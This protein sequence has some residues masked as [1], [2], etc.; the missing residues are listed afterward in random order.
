MIAISKPSTKRRYSC[1]CEIHPEK[2][3]RPA[4]LATNDMNNAIHYSK[5]HHTDVHP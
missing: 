3:L 5:F 4:E 1:S 2:A